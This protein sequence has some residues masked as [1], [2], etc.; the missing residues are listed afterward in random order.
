MRDFF[1]HLCSRAMLATITGP[2]DDGD[3]G[4]KEAGETSYEKIEFFNAQ[5][6]RDCV[7]GE[8]S[9]VE[10]MIDP[11]LMQVRDCKNRLGSTC[12]FA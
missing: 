10:A 12:S 4:E 6:T 3:E 7:G 9:H 2:D 11:V 5:L 8:A 1:T